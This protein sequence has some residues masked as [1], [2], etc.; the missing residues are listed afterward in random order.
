MRMRKQNCFYLKAIGIDIFEEL[1]FFLFG[2]AT[3]VKNNGIMAIGNYKSVFLK[4]IKSKSLYLYGHASKLRQ[5]C[6]SAAN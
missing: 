5:I 2:I 3:W 4:S 6:F 1:S